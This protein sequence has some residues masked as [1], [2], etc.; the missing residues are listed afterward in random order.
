MTVAEAVAALAVFPP[1]ARIALTYDSVV[2]GIDLDAIYRAA[3]G[4]V[5]I[6]KD[7]KDEFQSGELATE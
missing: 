7:Y 2:F 4:T 3:D 1:N 6:G 5:L